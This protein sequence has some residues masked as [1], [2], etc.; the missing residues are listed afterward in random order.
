M[1]L[2]SYSFVITG[3]N[4]GWAIRQVLPHFNFFQ[5]FTH[6]QH[7]TLDACQSIC[8]WSQATQLIDECKWVNWIERCMEGDDCLAK[9]NHICQYIW[10]QWMWKIRYAMASISTYVKSA[11]L[12]SSLHSCTTASSNLEWRTQFS[13][14]LPKEWRSS[15]CRYLHLDWLFYHCCLPL[16]QPL[17]LTQE[18][19]KLRPRLK[20]RATTTV[21]VAIRIA[22][23]TVFIVIT[24]PCLFLVQNWHYKSVGTTCPWSL[25]QL[26]ALNRLRLLRFQIEIMQVKGKPAALKSR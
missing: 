19:R 14:V 5:S 12:H 15:Y 4:R 16:Q 1:S 21:R 11:Q 2:G 10:K 25:A 13:S 24:L 18:D 7:E 3:S 23:Q 17:Q 26:A 22:L 20:W 6:Q 9:L 8:E